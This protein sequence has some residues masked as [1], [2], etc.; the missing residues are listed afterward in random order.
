MDGLLIFKDMVTF[1]N[2]I[3][4]EQVVRKSYIQE[5]LFANKKLVEKIKID[6]I[7]N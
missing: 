1:A 4:I 5:L 7:W 6:E 3:N 2:L